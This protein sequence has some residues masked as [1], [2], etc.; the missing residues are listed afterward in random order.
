MH[1][2]YNTGTAPRNRRSAGKAV[3]IAATAA[4]ILLVTTPAHAVLV[5][6]TIDPVLS[7]LG[8]TLEMFD[9]GTPSDVLK[10]DDVSVASGYGEPD[11]SN[12]GRP[13]GTIEMDWDP[14]V[15]I[16]FLTS[17]SISY[18]DA[19]DYYPYRDAIGDVV[20]PSDPNGIAAPAQFGFEQYYSPDGGANF[21]SGAGF[22]NIHGLS[23]TFGSPATGVVDGGSPLVFVGG[24]GGDEYVGAD[25][26]LSAVGGTLD[27]FGTVTDSSDLST[28][29][30]GGNP[31]PTVFAGNTVTF[32]GTTLE[33]PIDFVLNFINGTTNYTLTT[34]GSATGTIIA[35]VIPEPSSIVML[36]FGVVGLVGCCL[37]AR[38]R[39]RFRVGGRRSPP[40]TTW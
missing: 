18:L 8:I 20:A 26:A 11:P 38:K 36:G 32:D 16:Q 21:A 33:I 12:V 4:A 23:Q 9:V 1:T 35:H 22:A 7:S 5:T 28:F 14:D 27:W 30:P 10:L 3:A 24:I 31:L 39:R 37:R 40:I 34:F 15:S 2:D 29:A 19:F 25:V 13:F 17:S 6:L